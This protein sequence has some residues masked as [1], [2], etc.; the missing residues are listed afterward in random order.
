M[1]DT[2]AERSHKNYYES[3]GSGLDCI[4]DE[5][6]FGEYVFEFQAPAELYPG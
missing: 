2:Q 5:A 4:I 3:E 6:Q 1:T